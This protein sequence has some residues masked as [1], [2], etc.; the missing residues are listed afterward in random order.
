MNHH[1]ILL[2]AFLSA[3]VT[4]SAAQEPSSRID[5]A[6]VS[7]SP[8]RRFVVV[9]VPF[10]QDDSQCPEDRGTLLISAGTLALMRSIPPDPS[11]H[12]RV[13]RDDPAHR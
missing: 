9:D 5:L 8:F 12:V 6:V 2:S 10:A 13:E 7:D 4:A 3:L 11:T 1:T